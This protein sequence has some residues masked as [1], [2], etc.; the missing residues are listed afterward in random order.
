MRKKITL[1]KILSV[2]AFGTNV[3]KVGKL[4]RSGVLAD[5]IYHPN[6]WYFNDMLFLEDQDAHEKV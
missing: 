2:P 1:Q 3:K 5:D 6:M 4:M